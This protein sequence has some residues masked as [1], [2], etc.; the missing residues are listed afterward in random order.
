MV[1]RS[2]INKRRT[3]SVVCT[4]TPFSPASRRGSL[5]GLCLRCKGLVIARHVVIFWVNSISVIVCGVTPFSPA[6]RRESLGGLCLGCKGFVIG[7]QEVILWVN[8]IIGII[9]GV[10][11]LQVP[12]HRRSARFRQRSSFFEKVRTVVVFH[13]VILHSPPEVE[14]T[15]H[16]EIGHCPRFSFETK[17]FRH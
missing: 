11:P 14:R 17:L 10:K 6:S 16:E 9:C 7:R 5:G 13:K 4:A 2:S 3:R 15:R 8:P 1:C 12:K